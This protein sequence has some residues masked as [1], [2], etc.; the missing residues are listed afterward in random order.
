MSDRSLPVRPC[1]VLM[2]ETV[3]D[4]TP[5]TLQHKVYA[6]DYDPVNVSPS[7][8]YYNF[9]EG[10]G[11]ANGWQK[12]KRSRYALGFYITEVIEQ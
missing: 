9:G 6:I 12:L 1:K 2:Q 5:L 4:Y 10:Q 3:D 7:G 8:E 11:R